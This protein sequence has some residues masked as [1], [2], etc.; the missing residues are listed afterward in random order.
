VVTEEQTQHSVKPTVFYDIID[1]IY[2]QGR[3]VELFARK[4]REG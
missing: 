3:R 1:T 2:P 4:G